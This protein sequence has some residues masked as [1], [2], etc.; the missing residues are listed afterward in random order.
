[1]E[2]NLYEL[3]DDRKGFLTFSVSIILHSILLILCM[4]HKQPVSI[5]PPTIVPAEIPALL[6]TS[7]DD[8]LAAL[9]PRA[10]NFGIPEGSPAG[11]QYPVALP[12]QEEQR[13]IS[14]EH[15]AQKNIS[16]HSTNNHE[17][18]QEQAR[19]LT[20][21][22]TTFPH[23]TINFDHTDLAMEAYEH[24]QDQL[25]LSDSAHSV[26]KGFVAQSS[27]QQSSSRKISFADLAQ[28]FIENIRHEGNDWIKREGN[29]NKQPDE[30][31]LRKISYLQKIIW[32]MQ[33]E[34]RIHE[35]KLHI[36]HPSNLVVQLIITILKDGTIS[37][38]EKVTPSSDPEYDTFIING[39]H[40]CSP[41]LPLPKHFNTHA[42]DFGITIVCEQA[43]KPWRVNLH[44][45]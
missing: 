21:K 19:E 44:T 28:G 12:D 45:P 15:G 22:Q 2:G 29:E 17:Q 26:K 4:C 35:N 33:N 32:Y 42:F 36:T 27:G 10:N 38:I 37:H 9:H 25:P 41:L 13:G 8:T 31:D 7:F 1:M 30:Q 20:E 18:K 34:W 3:R 40:A 23:K 39:I 24:F 14:D 5:F 16:D 6:N 11:T 43:R